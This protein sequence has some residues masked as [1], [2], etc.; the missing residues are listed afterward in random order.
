MKLGEKLGISHAELTLLLNTKLN[1]IE[2]R[3]NYLKQLRKR[4]LLGETVKREEDKTM[5]EQEMLEKI[6]SLGIDPKYYISMN[7]IEPGSFLNCTMLRK[8]I[9]LNPISYKPEKVVLKP[10]IKESREIKVSLLV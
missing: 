1:T 4:L 8:A 5:K 10:Y 3:E 2:N 9:M 7:L 6:V